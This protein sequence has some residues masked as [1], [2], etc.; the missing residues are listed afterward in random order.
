M[1]LLS[2]HPWILFPPLPVVGSCVPIGK[3]LDLQAIG[4]LT[5]LLM[6]IPSLKITMRIIP[7]GVSYVCK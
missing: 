6:Y 5:L 7:E 2:I 3:P 4:R 1:L